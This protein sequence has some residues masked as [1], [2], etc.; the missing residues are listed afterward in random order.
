MVK[1]D[2]KSTLRDIITFCRDKMSLK[3]R[4]RSPG[5][6]GGHPRQAEVAAGRGASLGAGH[7][8]ERR[9]TLLLRNQKYD[10][11]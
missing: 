8:G 5:G 6:N 1:R 4:G 2:L 3:S 11:V 10:P 9:V 7:A